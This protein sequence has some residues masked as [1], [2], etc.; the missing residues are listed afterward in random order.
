[1]KRKIKHGL[2]KKIL[3]SN[4]DGYRQHLNQLNQA[5]EA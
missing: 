2:I 4:Q 3:F 5:T 1:M